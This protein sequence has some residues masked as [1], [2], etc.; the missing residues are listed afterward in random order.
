MTGLVQ[1][2]RVWCF[3]VMDASHDDP[4][5]ETGWA[6]GLESGFSLLDRAEP[7]GGKRAFDLVFGLLLLVLCGPLLLV[8]MLA[9]WLSSLG[10][11]PILYRQI[12]VGLG[13][14]QFTLLKLRTMR[15]DAERQGP[16]MTSINDPRITRLGRI[17]RRSRIDELPQL[18]NVLCGEMSLIGPRPERPEFAL[19]YEQVIDG[20]TCRYRVKPGITGLAQVRMGYAE[21]LQEAA[22]K[23]YYDF[24]YIRNSG[25]LRDL[26]ILLQTL[27][28]VITG[29]GAR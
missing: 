7:I 4:R 17:L 27:Y 18:I 2:D 13:G 5:L 8:A 14:R 29:R 6:D 16:R 10:R 25:P 22:L 19:R 9:L 26:A 11:D 24:D 3:D 1:N 28:V 20:Y 23:C 15:V 12:R 21:G